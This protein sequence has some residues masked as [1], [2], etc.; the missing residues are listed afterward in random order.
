MVFNGDEIMNDTT[1]R[2]L[3]KTVEKIEEH[4]CKLAGK[5]NYGI[6]NIL[7]EINKT[8]ERSNKLF[9]NEIDKEE[10]NLSTEEENDD[11]LTEEENNE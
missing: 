5:Y 1:E 4:L 3:I 8:L 10:D 6:E 7:H 2:K 11:L 9:E